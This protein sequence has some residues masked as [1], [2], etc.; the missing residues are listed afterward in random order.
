VDVVDI[1]PSLLFLAKRYFKV[2]ESPRLHNYVEDGRRFLTDSPKKYD[3]IFS[4]VYYSFFSVPPQFA[5]KEFFAIAKEK[6]S[7]NGILVANMIGDL[8]RQQPSL[9]MAEIKTFQAVFPNSYFF[10]VAWPEKTDSQNVMM[11]GYN[12][13]TAVDLNSP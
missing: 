8:S 5:T 4:D 9:I 10:A 6:L 7:P 1:E 3:L 12:S 2:P 11:V 13:D